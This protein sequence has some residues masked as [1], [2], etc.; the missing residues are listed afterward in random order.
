MRN[1]L[2]LNKYFFRYKW[3]LLS[4]T[5]FVVLSNYF[6]VLIPQK[7]GEA[8]DFVQVKISDLKTATDNQS[9]L[10]DEFNEVLLIFALT[11]IGFILLKGGLMY[12]MR[13]TIIVTSRLIEYDLRRDIFSKLE[14]LDTAYLSN[15]KTGDLMAR[16]TEDVSKV[17]NY[18]GPGI[19]YAINLVSLF[20]MTIYAMFKVNSELAL[21]TLLPL[22]FLSFSIY[23]VSSRINL[24]SS[25]I[26]KQL[27]KLNSVAQEV[28]SGIR[29]VKSYG[30][31]G[32]FNTYF[33]EQSEDYRKKSMELV[34]INAFFFPLM[35][36]L[37]NISTILV[38]L[39]G[40]SKV[41]SGEI[42]Y[43]NIAEFIIYVN[44]LTWPVTAIGWIA[45]IVQQAEASMSRINVLLDASPTMSNTNNEEYLIK[46][47]IAFE[48]VSFTYPDTKI[49][50]LKDLTFEIKEGER[51]AVIGKT[52]SGKST[53]VELLLRMYDTTTGR[54]L[55]DGKDIKNHN[56]ELLRREIGYVPQDVFLFSD[57]VASNIGF[58]KDDVSL[59]E[60]R[61][62]A[63][64]AAVRK[65]I[66]D[67]PNGFD[68][69]VGERGVSLSGGQKQRVSIA[70]ALIKNPSIVIMDDSLSAVDT[71]TEKRIIRFLDKTC[72]NKTT[73][74]VTHRVSGIFD[75]DKIL[76]LS[77]GRIEEFG[78]P[79]EL[80]S[81]PSSYYA[82]LLEEV[83]VE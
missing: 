65:D 27:G 46:G 43:G 61:V 25:I 45:S 75:F 5:L 15:F 13:Q 19:L 35:I 53:L 79:S 67:L 52:A 58:A 66:E 51:V 6:G 42:T 59:E 74:I 10:Y 63:G 55:I 80:A 3:Y 44:M 78:S 17:R 76:V 21:Y 37:I 68:T 32:E 83:M 60:I 50:A 77:E 73:I 54:I 22:P 16:I 56:V 31:E 71:E 36:L 62:M 8:L 38:L 28:F 23:W 18:L 30:K 40:G 20:V 48:G 81:N 41:S 7:I 4:G 70:R 24:H 26:Q 2:K 69:M 64:N 72:K 1:L 29:V 57:T 12:L 11:V 14:T 9:S 49:E 39:V 34:K 33:E 47:G 82:Q